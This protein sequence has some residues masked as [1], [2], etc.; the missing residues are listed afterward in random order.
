MVEIKEL[1]TSFVEIF[2]M[3][4]KLHCTMFGMGRC[5]ATSCWSWLNPNQFYCFG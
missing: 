1:K 4:S 5:G 2:G 3:K